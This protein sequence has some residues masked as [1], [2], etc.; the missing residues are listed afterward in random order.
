[1]FLDK[2]AM[3]SDVDREPQT[4]QQIANI[5]FVPGQIP[6]NRVSVNRKP[7]APYQYRGRGLNALPAENVPGCLHVRCFS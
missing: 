5:H 4:L 7:H 6:P 3:K 1:M 2:Y